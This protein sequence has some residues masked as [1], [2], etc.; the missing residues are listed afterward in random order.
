MSLFDIVEI[1]KPKGNMEIVTWILFLSSLFFWVTLIL[2]ESRDNN[3]VKRKI[4]G[5]ANELHNPSLYARELSSF[6]DWK[7]RLSQETNVMSETHL[8]E[9]LASALG[10][11]YAPESTQEAGWVKS[12]SV[13]AKKV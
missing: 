2:H 6:V 10:Y 9:K 4:N 7:I 13:K 8:V 12:S 11:M 1:V 3:D 5:L